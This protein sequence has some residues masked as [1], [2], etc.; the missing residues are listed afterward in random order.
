MTPYIV[1]KDKSIHL[2]RPILVGIYIYIREDLL[3]KPDI[4]WQGIQSTSNQTRNRHVD[5]DQSQIPHSW[6]S[7]TSCLHIIR[8]QK[9]TFD[10]YSTHLDQNRCVTG[11]LSQRTSPPSNLWRISEPFYTARTASAKSF[12]IFLWRNNLCW[13]ELINTHIWAQL[14]DGRRRWLTR[15]VTMLQNI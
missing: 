14:L 1:T 9:T 4:T 3:A 12:N 7:R 15:L 8:Q 2:L 11:T 6:G 5:L 13:A 10:S